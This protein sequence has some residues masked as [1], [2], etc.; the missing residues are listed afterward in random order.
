MTRF[1]APISI[2]SEMCQLRFSLPLT[3]SSSR[4]PSPPLHAHT[5]LLHRTMTSLLLRPSSSRSLLS[6]F[7][8]PLLLRSFSTTP[9]TPYP[10]AP[11][12]SSSPSPPA[13][14]PKIKTLNPKRDP[15]TYGI[16]A[17]GVGQRKN[18]P[19]QAETNTDGHPLWKFFH[20]GVSLEVPNRT[21]DNSSESFLLIFLLF[22]R[23]R[24]MEGG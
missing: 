10:R 20:R 5:H 23:E 9:P 21:E 1:L 13:H 18:W 24:E 11:R 7:S 4:R 14:V 16:P 22:A 15:T 6:P 12:P 8:L 3:S 19:K 17:G 2:G